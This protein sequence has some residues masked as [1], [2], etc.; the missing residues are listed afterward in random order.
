MSEPLPRLT[1]EQEDLV[2]RST[3]VPR[4][5][6]RMS[7]RTSYLTEAELASVGYETE[8]RCATRFEPARNVPFEAYSYTFVHLDMKKAIGKERT[9]QRR[10]MTGTLDASYEY[11]ER[12]R[13]P[14]DL[15]ADTE[16]DSRRQLREFAEGIMG[17]FLARFL[18]EASQAPSEDDLHERDD[19]G[20]KRVRV[21][22]AVEAMGEAGRVLSLKYFDRLTWEEV[23]ARVGSSSATVRRDH[24]AA[25][26]T[27][28][29]R[30]AGTAPRASRDDDK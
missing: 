29:A 23:A 7:R 13:D 4:L 11:L 26:R 8:C 14:G 1:K 22:A 5:A 28:A 16:A 30:L 25:L 12:Y 3:V 19:R 21:R 20:R 10:E 15:F 18:S 27:L 24:D 9:K 2:R 6:R 17:T